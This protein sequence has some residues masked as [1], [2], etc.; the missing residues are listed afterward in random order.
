MAEFQRAKF[1]V[2]Q[3]VHHKLFDYRG[4]VVDVD[5]DFQGADKWDEALAGSGASKNQPWYYI[6]V[7]DADYNTYVA[8]RNLEEDWSDEEINHPLVA[9]MFDKAKN[10]GYVM[11]RF[12]H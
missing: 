8:E 4:I 12:S 2:G 9:D 7:H 6:L 1:R 10:G 3:L 11:R 5:P